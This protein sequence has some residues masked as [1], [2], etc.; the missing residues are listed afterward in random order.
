MTGAYIRVQRN[1][2]YENVEVEYLTDSEREE[3]FTY[4]TPEE[5]INWLNLVCKELTKEL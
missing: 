1:G 2:T 3:T 5:L 4:R